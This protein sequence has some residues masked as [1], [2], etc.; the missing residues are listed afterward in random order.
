MDCAI[1][2]RCA[3]DGLLLPFANGAHLPLRPTHARIYLRRDGTEDTLSAILDQQL[4]NSQYAKCVAAINLSL[5][6]D[7]TSVNKS[8]MHAAATTPNR[9]HGNFVPLPLLPPIMD[10]ENEERSVSYMSARTQSKENVSR[11]GIEVDTSRQD[12]PNLKIMSPLA[13]QQL[14]SDVKQ[15]I[16]ICRVANGE[17]PMKAMLLGPCP[18]MHM[19][20]QQAAEDPVMEADCRA[21]DRLSLGVGRK[22]RDPVNL[23]THENAAA[24]YERPSDRYN[25]KQS[26]KRQA[27]AHVKK[28]RLLT[29][30][31]GR[32][33]QQF[34]IR[35]D[36][37]QFRKTEEFMASQYR[38]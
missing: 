15:P 22:N 10:R 3:D 24:A 28:G 6:G 29:G 30:R 11:P 32:T 37:Q 26:I 18:G 13:F 34:D 38:P 36:L 9:H 14:G 25:K 33:Q 1:N 23:N 19:A 5:P 35:T 31:K 2:G 27:G 7:A 8:G 20:H 17:T 21:R 12:G 16:D 4:M